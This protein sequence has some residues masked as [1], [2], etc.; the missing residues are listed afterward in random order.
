[1]NL[2]IQ[3]LDINKKLEILNHTFDEA[4][5]YLNTHKI[6]DINNDKQLFFYAHYKQATVGKC[7][8]KQ[9]S[10]F[11]FVGRSKWN[12]WNDLGNMD[13][14]DAKIEYMT[15]L[16]TLVPHWLDQVTKETEDE[17]NASASSTKTEKKEVKEK[18]HD[19]IFESDSDD[20]EA[21]EPAQ[22]KGTM[23]PVMS[24]F[25]MVDE[26][27][28]EESKN[29]KKDL[30]YYVSSDELDIVRKML[31]TAT[32]VEEESLKIMVNERDEQGRT[33]LIWGCDRGNLEM[34]QL[35]IESGAN[36]NDSDLDG[37]TSLHYACMCS[38][39]NVIKLLLENGARKDLTDNEQQTPLQMV[40]HLEKEILSLFN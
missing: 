38:H 32:A 19:D 10:L 39:Y 21:K 1:M 4:V 30:C 23:G 17:M 8:T 25:S 7:N 18:N 11:D 26:K 33:P 31:T 36:I 35:L 6:A 37:L 24:R 2:D 3:E 20:E 40:D 14:E 9:P 13:K 28:L 27:I 5:K 12:S 22:G 16:E 29:Q 15:F 34:V